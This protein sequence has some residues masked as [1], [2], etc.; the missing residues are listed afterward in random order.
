VYLS[1]LHKMVRFAELLAFPPYD[2]LAIIEA[3]W[4]WLAADA[5]AIPVPRWRLEIIE[6]RSAE[7]DAETNVAAR[8]VDVRR[9]IERR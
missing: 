7:D 8:W 4:D 6:Q 9:R 5:S 2:R 3:L 1:S